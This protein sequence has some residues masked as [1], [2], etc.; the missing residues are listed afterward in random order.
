MGKVKNPGQGA[1]IVSLQQTQYDD[2]CTLRIYGKLD[3]VMSLLAKE[4]GVAIDTAMFE[5]K[6][7]K[8]VQIRPDVFL[9]PYD[10]QGNFSTTEKTE[11]DLSNRAKIK[12]TAGPGTG[13][14]GI[15]TGKNADGHFICRLP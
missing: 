6:I 11:W 4:I 3:V 14:E 2:I 7:P 10:K 9:V 15:I 8:E 1:V 12:V 13:Y 5:P